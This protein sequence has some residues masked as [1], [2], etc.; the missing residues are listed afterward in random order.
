MKTRI[1]SVMIACLV[2]VTSS[3]CFASTS[4]ILTS[5][6][7]ARGKL[8][9]LV[10]T[11]DKGTQTVLVDQVKSATQ[12]VDKNVAATL[13]DAATPADVKGKLTEFKAVWLEF[14]H[15]RD[16]EIIPAV[17]SG[18]NAKAKE[19]AQGVQVERFK[20]MVSLLQ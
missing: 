14:Q 2:G 18:D 3:S 8:V 15:T 10:G 17:L 6:Q 5:L 16:A 1:L 20:K 19:I 4:D 12:E 13:A 11:T 7:A 9:S